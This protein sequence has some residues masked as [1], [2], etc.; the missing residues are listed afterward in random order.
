MIYYKKKSWIKKLKNGIENLNIPELNA[1]KGLFKNFIIFIVVFCL[2]IYFSYL[3]ILPKFINEKNVENIINAALKK[4]SDI[5]FDAVNLKINPK[6]NLNINLSADKIKIFHK[7]Q[8]NITLNK[9]DIDISLI[10]LFFGY[11]D[12]NKIKVEKISINST[13]TK[14]HRYSTASFFKTEFKTESK[15]KIKLRNIHIIAD[16]IILKLYDENINKNFYIKTDKTK[17]YINNENKYSRIITKG[18]IASNK[19]LADINLN[20]SFKTRKNILKKYKDITEKLNYNPLFYADKF[21]FYSDINANLKITPLEKKTDII[22]KVNLKNYSFSLSDYKLP[23]NNLMLIFKGDS[24]S[25]DCDFKFINNQFIKIQ[26]KASISKNKFIEAE[27]KSNEINLKDLDEILKV[28]CNILNLKIDTSDFI[29]LGNIKANLYIKSNFKKINSKGLLLI[30]N[31]GLIHKKTNLALKNINSNINFNNNKIDIIN[32]S[33]YIGEAKFYLK[34]IIDNNTNLNIDIN[35]DL[36]NIAKIIS[37]V[38]S[39]PFADKINPQIDNYSFKSGLLKINT[40]I[41]GNLNLPVIKTNSQLKNFKVLL[42]EYNNEISLK[43]AL[44]SISPL[45]NNTGNIFIKI[46]GSSIAINRENLNIHSVKLNYSKDSVTIEKTPFVFKGSSGTFEGNI[47]TKQKE[48]NFNILIDSIKNNK[49]ISLNQNNQSLI[50]NITYKNKKLFINS[51]NIADSIYINGLVNNTNSKNPKFENIKI[52]IPNKTSISLKTLCTTLDLKGQITLNGNIKNP[53]ADGELNVY[54][55]YNQ[56]FNLKLNDA[57]LNFRNSNVYINAIN[58]K[59]YDTN[60]D[61]TAEAKYENNKIIFN[62]VN[63]I[64]NYVNLDKLSSFT[65]NKD[66]QNIEY[67]INNLKGN[68]TSLEGANLLLDS[69][70]FEGNIKNNILKITNLKALVFNGIINGEAYINLKTNKVLADLILKE[71]NVRHLTTEF[72]ELSIAASGKLSALLKVEFSG[73]EFSDI[74]KTIKGYI[75]FNIDNGEL[76]QFAK[77][78]RYLQAGNILSSNI[79]KLTLNSTLSAITKQNTG[80]F[81]TIEGTVNLSDSKASIQYIK[82][83]GSNM[84]TY[85]TGNF[86]LINQYANVK[87]LGRIPYSMVSV[88]GNI[89]KFSLKD[90]VDKMNENTKDVIKTITVSPVEK[91]MSVEIPKEQTDKIPPLAYKDPTIPT[92]EFIVFIDGNIKNISSIKYFKWNLKE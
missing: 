87:V 43:E 51:L 75:K 83:Q 63:I 5:G 66:I 9:A 21:N 69:V 70:I 60:F 50:S 58:A 24:I 35:S 1:F 8:D 23:K 20:I 88:F 65:V 85:I 19:K 57:I 52:L 55:L 6:Y 16:K 73:F 79:L 84:S 15:G 53:L 30:K 10:T 67:E 38:K 56:K 4:Q 34:G 12:L 92:R 72:K 26:S 27:I 14:Q 33:A 47:K 46:P 81:K 90:S 2:A 11:L 40:Q 49:F 62:F 41:K 32:T 36:I 74:L 86:N 22:G 76:S 25:T 71:L 45:K 48:L 39:L 77:L 17:I 42:K 37:L 89:G 3:F 78:E 28:F 13:F 59:F 18:S 82:T 80:D 61:L 54:N 7:N 44:I 64:A 91:M 31:A 68:I 29:L